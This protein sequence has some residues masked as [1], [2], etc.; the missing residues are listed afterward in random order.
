[1]NRRS[2]IDGVARDCRAG[3]YGCANHRAMAAA[4]GAPD[5]VWSL[6]NDS[7][8]YDGER[9]AGS[10][11]RRQIRLRGVLSIQTSTRSNSK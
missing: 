4:A 1:M 6:A 10:G 7:R 3:H 9:G 11:T 2:R 5:P 8:L